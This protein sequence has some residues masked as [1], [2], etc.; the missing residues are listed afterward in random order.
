ML[1]P[2]VSPDNERSREV[3]PQLST[4]RTR[5]ESLSVSPVLAYLWRSLEAGT[6][7]GYAG[8]VAFAHAARPHLSE[9]EIV[10]LLET[11]PA[12]NA[13]RARILL[14]QTPSLPTASQ[15]DLILEWM[16]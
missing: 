14:H 15:R 10:G 4:D 8:R 1:N 5:A 7:V 3:F 6:G 12:Q 11:Q 13:E 9:D 16:G 2:S